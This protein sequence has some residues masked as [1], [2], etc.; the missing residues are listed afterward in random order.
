MREKTVCLGKKMERPSADYEETLSWR[1]ATL[2]EGP[3]ILIASDSQ[4][5]AWVK[6]WHFNYAK[7]NRFPVAIADFGMSERQVKWCSRRFEVIPLRLPKGIF[8]RRYLHLKE[9]AKENAADAQSDGPARFKKPFALLNSPFRKTLWIDLD[10]LVRASVAPLF[11][12]PSPPHFAAI[13]ID[14]SP[15]RVKERISRNI[16]T[17]GDKIYNTGVIAYSHGSPL[18]L[19]WAKETV[20]SD[21]YF[22]GDQ[23][24]F[25]KVAQ[26]IERE[27]PL[28][29]KNYN[30]LV[31]S[32]GFSK[33]AAVIH[34]SGKAKG[35]GEALVKDFYRIAV[36]F[37]DT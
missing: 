15:E 25:S 12:L 2:S 37:P 34:F 26:G 10:C 8:D 18:I 20:F 33:N 27:I 36:N 21:G 16:L 6:W 14:E 4:S 17:P 23:D 22:I 32:Y 13:G 3:G 5:E 28:V 29:P 35:L 30:W 31:E 9:L 24:I 11:E 19:K 7:W 1:M